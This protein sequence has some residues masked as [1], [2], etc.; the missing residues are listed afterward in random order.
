LT[1]ASVNWSSPAL[2]RTKD[3]VA[4]GISGFIGPHN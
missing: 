1:Q 4:L 3:T 2:P